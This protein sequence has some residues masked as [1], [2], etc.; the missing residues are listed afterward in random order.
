VKIEL[1][2]Q[3]RSDAITSIQRHFQENMP[4]PISTGPTSNAS[5]TPRLA[6]SPFPICEYP[7]CTVFNAFRS[8]PK[9]VDTNARQVGPGKALAARCRPNRN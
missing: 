1:S 8:A 6:P 5:G 7:R 2:K 4:E 9:P 3:A